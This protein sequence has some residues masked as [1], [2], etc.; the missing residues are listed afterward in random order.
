MRKILFIIIA[1]FAFWSCD[2]TE[3]SYSIDESTLKAAPD[4]A[5]LIANGVYGAFWQTGYT[6][7][8]A[9]YADYDSDHGNAL[10]WLL[11]SYGS[12]VLDNYLSGGIYQIYYQIVA[13]AN[14]AIEAIPEF[15]GTPEVKRNQLLGE[16]YFIRAFMYFEILRCWGK[17]PLRVSF[18]GPNDM[19]RASVKEVAEHIISD[20]NKADNLMSE[21]GMTATTWGRA[22]KTAVKLL[23][24]RVY[25]SIGAS[26]L[27]KTGVEIK[28]DIK[29][30]KTNFITKAV[31]GYES[32]N[33]TECYEQVEKLC[34]EV[35]AR[36]DKEFGLQADY[37]S[38][39]G[40][41]NR[42][43]KEFVWGVAGS[44]SYKFGHLSYYYTA[45]YYGGY[46]WAG[47]SKYLYDLYESSDNRG[48]HGVFHYSKQLISDDAP[49]YRFPDDQA[50][51][52]SPD[53]KPTIFDSNSSMPFTTKWYVGDVANPTTDSGPVGYQ[54]QDMPLI[55]YCDAYLLRAEALNELDRP[56]QALADLKVIRDRANASDRSA[57]T[58]KVDIRSA[59]LEERALE[60][61]A[62]FNRRYDLLRWGLYLDVMNATQS[63]PTTNNNINKTRDQRGLLWAIPLTE[64]NSN[65]LCGKENNP[66]Y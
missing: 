46:G 65:K 39:W 61:V 57:L 18:N 16:V 19:P 4:G 11:G 1:S 35:I 3:K 58:S 2:L 48:I 50:Y 32:F 24:A 22:N 17:V 15:T 40:N 21:W 41:A 53:G 38:I 27:A 34:N 42:R 31:A 33:A 8:Y 62:E 13:R 20:L 60:F 64:I 47:F 63:I 43:N 29:G 52:I 25:A 49:W 45:I 54:D 9:G 7:Y 44:P 36:R 26:A 5:E 28:V 37:Q 12:G 30:T 51:A 56:Q 59:I 14:Y 66:G 10:G 6:H 55:R 23:L